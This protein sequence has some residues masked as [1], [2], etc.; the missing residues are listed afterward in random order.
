MF[1]FCVKSGNLTAQQT[2]D[3]DS[4]AY[5]SE[6]I[7]SPKGEKDLTRIFLYF[8]KAKEESIK[9]NDTTGIIYNL[10]ML[11]IAEFRL[12][13]YQESK[14]SAIS[15]LKLVDETEINDWTLG[16]IIS[17]YNSLGKAH[18]ELND[19]E[20]AIESYDNVLRL[21]NNIDDCIKAYNNK[22][23]V[24]RD[25]SKLR[26]A[27][28]EFSFAND[29]DYLNNKIENARVLGNM[30]FVQAKLE[31]PNGIV[32][33]LQALAI[34]TE[35]NNLT[36]M[37]SSSINLTEY[38]RYRDVDSA[39][40]YSNKAFELSKKINSPI[41]KKEAL[42]NLLKLE[43]NPKYVEYLDIE[44]K[45]RE[46]ELASDIKFSHAKYNIEKERQRALN[47]RLLAEAKNKRQRLMFISGSII[48]LLIVFFLYLYLRSKHKK[49]KVKVAIRETYQT[50]R[51]L[52]KKVHDELANDMSDILNFIGR[53]AEIPDSVKKPLENKMDNIYDR[54]RDISAEIGGF[55]TANFTQSLHFLIMQHHT[56]GL[57][58][59]TNVNA[60]IDWDTLP[61]YKKTNVYRC[62]QE[63]LVNM[64][65]HS[66]AARVS[67]MFKK[68][69]NTYQIQYT[70]NG[71]GAVIDNVRKSGLNNMETRMQDINGSI[72]FNSSINQGFK[73]NLYFTN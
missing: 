34:R 16:V 20:N 54:T 58:V 48:F 73:A 12:G 61:N 26:L 23:N 17:L 69:G 53:Q 41:Y 14:N 31:D 55:D 56:E 19:Y 13:A 22:A 3:R 40:M 60:G 29:L 71:K 47:Q 10:S 45:L 30:G 6:L 32:N 5:W 39:L 42:S 49:E 46:S 70:D 27:L 2:I 21:S 72:T 4:I 52:S 15:A 68:E 36:G 67:I 37:F 24:Y 9:Q 59:L 25:E 64:K 1:L 65:K 11:S 8:D 33:M 66:E 7:S 35:E 63:L 44:S 18:K 57:Q 62:L 51:R 50:E 28:M 38:Y 43:G